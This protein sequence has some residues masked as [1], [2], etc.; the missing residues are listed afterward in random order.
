MFEED[1]L[2][3]LNYNSLSFLAEVMLCL[4]KREVVAPLTCAEELLFIAEVTLSFL[5]EPDRL[6]ILLG[7][8]CD[9]ETYDGFVFDTKQRT[10]L[11]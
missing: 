5:I 1:A 3:L 7:L 2:L 9:G 6:L 8:L 4:F 11:T 10:S